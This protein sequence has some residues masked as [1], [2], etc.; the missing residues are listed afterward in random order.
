MEMGE[1]SVL[2]LDWGKKFKV[3]MAL[4]F[5]SSNCFSVQKKFKWLPHSKVK[6]RIS[7]KVTFKL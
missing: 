6:Y 5:K 4:P 1:I 2:I 3:Q 7:D